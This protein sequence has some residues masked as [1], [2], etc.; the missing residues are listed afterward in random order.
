MREIE[1]PFPPRIGFLEA[2]EMKL[3]EGG[4]NEMKLQRRNSEFGNL[5]TETFHTNLSLIFVGS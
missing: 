1:T 2:E 5:G 4:N 3:R